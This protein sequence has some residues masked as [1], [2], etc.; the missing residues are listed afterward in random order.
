MNPFFC[1]HL[2]RESGEDVIGSAPSHDTYIAIECRQPWAPSAFDSKFLPPN[3]KALVEEVRRTKRS[4]RFL[5]VSA[6]TTETQGYTRVLTFRKM[7]PPSQGYTRREFRVMNIAEVAPIVERYLANPNFVTVA[8]APVDEEMRDFLI[9]THGSHDKCCARYGNPFYREAL[10]LKSELGWKKVRFWQAS[11]IGGHRFAPT[12][13][14]LPDGR[15]YGGLDGGSMTAIS[16]KAG[17]IHY[18]EKVYRGWGILPRKVQVLE[19]QL[20]LQHGW[21]WLNYRVECEMVREDSELTIVR[22]HC[23]K[24]GTPP[25]IYEAEIVE[26]EC[27]TLEMRGSCGSQKESKFPKYRV[28][29]LQLRSAEIAIALA[30]SR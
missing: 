6:S 15:Y 1:A 4:V 16:Q 13:I 24:P 5:L 11:H 17:D 26:D 3:L 20:L 29:K 27:K 19:R 30:T 10:K 28:Q 23:H 22:L 18:F 8:S 7:P 21:D 12:M 2:S 25:W 9:C 14:S